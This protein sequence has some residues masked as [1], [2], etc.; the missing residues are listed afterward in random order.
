MLS[1]VTKRKN[2][3]DTK[4]CE[5]SHA[6]MPVDPG[7]YSF[8]FTEKD[9][10]CLCNINSGYTANWRLEAFNF[11]HNCSP[12]TWQIISNF[13]ELEMLLSE[14]SSEL[15]RIVKQWQ[16]CHLGSNFPSHCPRTNVIMLFGK[17]RQ[18]NCRVVNQEKFFSASCCWV[19]FDPR[20]FFSCVL[21][22]QKLLSSHVGLGR[23]FF[24]GSKICKSIFC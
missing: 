11:L 22:M 5:K 23:L 17:A 16:T 13:R 6:G 4:F 9:P 14:V 8:A 2:D 21:F 1:I 12:F 24:L 19:N 3:D 20:G 15:F 18:P 7:F 10:K